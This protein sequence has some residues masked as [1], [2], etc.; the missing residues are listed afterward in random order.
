MLNPSRGKLFLGRLVSGLKR[1]RS[2]SRSTSRGRDRT[3]AFYCTSPGTL[4]TAHDIAGH[5]RALPLAAYAGNAGVLDRPPTYSCA[6]TYNRTFPTSS[7]P[8]LHT[9]LNIPR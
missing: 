5:A 1:T 9:Q 3:A 6:Q 4:D 7:A 8:T 2:E